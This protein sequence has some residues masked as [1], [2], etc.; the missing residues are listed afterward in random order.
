MFLIKAGALLYILYRERGR[1]REREKARVFLIKAG[2]L[3]YILLLLVVEGVATNIEG[4][5]CS[6]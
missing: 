4:R 2:A 5:R 6:T 1:E 3:L